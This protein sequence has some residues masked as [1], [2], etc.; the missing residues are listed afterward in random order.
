METIR[1]VYVLEAG[2]IAQYLA[3]PQNG[4]LARRNLK[5]AFSGFYLT[6]FQDMTFMIAALDVSQIGDQHKYE[7]DIPHQISTELSDKAGRRIPIYMSNTTG[8]RYV[9]LLS[10]LPK[11]PS[12]ID[13]P[14]ASLLSGRVGI[15]Q[16]FNGK[17]IV[18]SWESLGHILITGITRSGKSALL[19][20]LIHQ[21]LRDGMLIGISDLDRV[22]FNMLSGHPALF[23][24][25]TTSPQETQEL[26]NRTLGEC[27]ARAKM[28][29][30]MPGYPENIKEYNELA[31]KAGK[32]PLP[33]ILL[34]LDEF[35]STMM[36][37]GS[38]RNGMANVLASLGMRGLK[39]GVTVVFAA[40]NFTLEQVGLLRDQCATIVCF[41]TTSVE[42]ARKMGCHGAQNIPDA[43][44]GRAI[45]N[46]WG[47]VQT[48]FVDK[49]LLIGSRQNI[50]HDAVDPLVL[51]VFKRAA[52][53]HGG[54][55]TLGLIK[56]EMGQS[57]NQASHK[58]N[59]WALMGW[60]A[61]DAAQ[62][63]AY[64]LTER[65]LAQIGREPETTKTAK[66]AENQPGSPKTSMIM[67]T[68]D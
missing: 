17:I 13:L 26:I 67:A 29:E 68:G 54:R 24:P 5:P 53:V 62:S 15:G 28:F 3:D 46:R 6:A 57:A 55:V 47:P 31:L 2:R 9:A 63:N 8:L 7:G 38:G 39:F 36:A 43:G 1:Q 48:F 49:S 34:V 32:Q 61:K 44:K 42:M 33:R 56:Q 40:H 30:Q 59:E 12:H 21:A 16:G 14:P 66:N 11:M 20:S 41:K 27:D 60:I 25:I 64:V 37:M 19:R 50:G 22:S 52:T 65:G 58:Q 4:A 23:A 18:E 45:T 51:S 35:N 10:T